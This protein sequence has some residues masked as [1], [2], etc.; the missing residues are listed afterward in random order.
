MRAAD[1]LVPA[2]FAQQQIW[3]RDRQHSRNASY[4]I[5]P[6]FRLRGSLDVNTLRGSLDALVRRH[7]ALRTS[8]RV[9]GGQLVQVI[10][11]TVEVPIRRMTPLEPTALER[12][13]AG[14]AAA[15]TQ[16]A[17]PFDLAKP[18]LVRV[19]LCRVDDDDHILAFCFHHAIFDSWSE[20]LLL[21]ELADFYVASDPRAT[22]HSDCGRQYAD[23]AIAQQVAGGKRQTIELD[24]DWSAD[25]PSRLN[26]PLDYPRPLEYRHRG[27]LESIF[28]PGPLVTTLERI[29]DQQGVEMST[30]LLGA[31]GVMLHRYSGDEEVEIGVVEDGRPPGEEF[32]RV[33]GCFSSTVGVSVDL[34]G[35]PSFLTVLRRTRDARSLRFS[36]PDEGGTF[37]AQFAI[38]PAPDT[39]SS[40]GDLRVTPL[41]VHN[42]M[43]GCDLFFSI[44]P[45][46]S[47]RLSCALEFDADLFDR[48]T[49][50][51]LL[52][53]YKLLLE[54][55]VAAVERPIGVLP[56]VTEQDRSLLACWSSRENR[57]PKG[58]SVHREFS[59]VAAASPSAV[60]LSTGS[61]QLTYAQLEAR[62]NQLARW[63]LHERVRRGDLVGVCMDRS[64][65]AIVAQL[66]ILKAGAAYLPLDPSYPSSQLQ[67]ML[68]DAGVRL[69]L[70]GASTSD[71]L[72]RSDA[73][74][75]GLDEE[76]RL[77]ENGAGEPILDNVGGEDL[78]YVMYTSGS[79]GRPNGV[80]IPHRGVLRLVF[81][82]DFV[83][84]QRA[85]TFLQMASL[86][87]DASTFEVW[88]A[89]LHG[90]K[91]V[92]FPDRVPTV[93]TLGDV[94]S[95][96][97]VDCLWLTSG[98]FNVVVDEHPECLDGVS[99]L[100]VGG[101]A[102]SV[103][104]V[105][106]AQEL[107][108][109]VDLINGYGPT[110]C[111]TFACCYPIPRLSPEDRRSIPIGRPIGST[112]AQ[113]WD[114]RKHPVPIGV[115]GQLYIGGDGVALGY[116]DRPALTAEGFI[117]D[118]TVPGRR[119][120]GTGDY[121]R[122]R[123]DGVLEFLGRRDSQV[124]IRGFR[125]E[126]GEVEAA[127]CQHPA[128]R[129]A[130]V[131]VVSGNQGDVALRAFVAK[132]E[133]NRALTSSEMLKF[134]ALNLPRH[135]VP[136]TVVVCN[137]FPLTINGKVDREA[138]A[139]V[140]D[141]EPGRREQFDRPATALEQTLCRIWSELLQVEFVGLDD[142]FFAIG[143]H[144]L[145]AVRMFSRIHDVLGRSLPFGALLQYPTV[146][147][148]AAAL[149]P[150]APA[151]VT[152]S[153]LVPL[154][155][156]GNRPPIFF[157]HGIGNEVFTFVEL[158]K[159]LSG[160]QPVFG[161]I[162][163]D[164]ARARVQCIEDM[165]S[166]YL[167]EV[168]A[169]V[170]NR[171]FILGGHCTGA[172]TAFEMARQR[173]LRGQTVPLLI[174]FD[175]W[176]SEEPAGV[177]RS[178]D[179]LVNWVVDDFLR[180]GFQNNVGRAL[181]KFRLLQGRVQRHL[182]RRRSE[183]DLRDV[184]GMW[185]YPDHEVERLQRFSEATAAYRFLPH[186]GPIHV[187]RARTR[188]LRMSQPP[189]DMGWSRIAQGPLRVETVRGSHD[190][191]FK[192]PFVQ[193]LARRVEAVVEEYLKG[194][195]NQQ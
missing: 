157:V 140:A 59:L 98:L 108:P 117:P 128:V 50:T 146:A 83:D 118:P 111:T 100:V 19:M 177:V 159:E 89:L 87:F 121:V 41:R 175:Y 184:L 113:V 13:D 104:H 16:A 137:S 39:D 30:T 192:A 150:P 127:C 40:I 81:G 55:V 144:S 86:S 9:A 37:Q 8:L 64:I 120:Y 194:A 193:T 6:T 1:A 179:N 15:A 72:P 189:D 188:R 28:L 96:E 123:N 167:T 164:A 109:D 26:L 24:R 154:K 58:S 168:E 101:E 53:S 187:F 95:T 186:D 130:V 124:K 14:L 52:E 77:L 129:D 80:R 185:R 27:G 85:T 91:L 44:A 60:A 174:V 57:Y 32:A 155:P 12:F 138:L 133:P 165:A 62:A 103:S 139:M 79:T 178:A 148:L 143:G 10:A 3:L 51:R 105:R 48:Q 71:L 94:L 112:T 4:N 90:A 125:I 151:R 29:G 31:Y 99:Q 131:L 34:R 67:F 158:A 61:E 195:G 160:D 70:T 76:M 17:E 119:L 156:G 170:Q 35:N 78:A 56:V 84:W 25:V 42:G 93:R 152:T 114:R 36:Q 190:S 147:K 49:A 166:S 149:E 135:L 73:T 153:S 2:S 66:A 173:H 7:G 22:L 171:P 142:D 88:G 65:A 75:I 122:W 92:I 169:M 115:R 11:P 33:I 46:D 183:D 45:T 134:L 74:V 102:L 162:P 161:V 191:M 18:P 126:P 43:S 141:G 145:L 180:T 23:F 5:A 69:V 172:V 176:F 106:R 110:E 54:S 182:M 181:S 63:L 38:H 107:L 116:H 163:S 136:A 21:R 82:T 20:S 132:H 47:G 68:G 97:R